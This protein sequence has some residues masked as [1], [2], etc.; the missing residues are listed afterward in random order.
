MKNFKLISLPFLKDENQ[1]I[2]K[3]KSN[4]DQEE[5]KFIE[6][7]HENQPTDKKFQMVDDSAEL[8]KDSESLQQVSD[9]NDQN[10]FIQIKLNKK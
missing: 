1:Q 9:N 7:L 4:L 8:V 2:E 6:T 3:I 5:E 10:N